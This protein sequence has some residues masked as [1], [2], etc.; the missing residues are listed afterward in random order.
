VPLAGVVLPAKRAAPGGAWDCAGVAAR[1]GV[2]VY[3]N[4]QG[5]PVREARPRS[6]VMRPESLATLRACV[7]TLQHPGDGQDDDA[8]VGEVTAENARALWHGHV[9]EALADTP[10]PGLVM[11]WQRLA[12]AEVH[13]A[14]AAGTV[15]LSCGYEA[16]LRDPRDPE[17]AHLVAELGPEPF[18]THGGERYDLLQTQIRYNHLAVVD[19][20]RAGHIARL[21]L[22]GR[23]AMKITING[24]QHPIQPFVAKAIKA[25]ALDTAAQA[26]AKTDALEVGEITIE[27]QALVLPKA[28]IDQILAMLGGNAGPSVPEPMPT[29]AAPPGAVPPP[30]DPMLMGDAEDEPKKDEK[31]PKAKADAGDIAAQVQRLVRAEMAKLQPGATKAI[32]DSVLATSRE[33]ASLERDASLV[34]GVRH[35][36]AGQDDHAVAVSVLKADGS[37]RVAR[38]EQLETLARKGDAMAAGRLRQ[39]MDDVLDRRRDDQDSSAEMAGWMFDTAASQARVDGKPGDDET[40]ERDRVRAAKRDARENPRGAA[41]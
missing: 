20:A 25:D 23:A 8:G 29:D 10:T 9:I 5:Q 4:E 32:A 33:R 14:T 41:A 11:T 27:G 38:A 19:L 17:V 26:K 16:V 35:D 31:D 1:D 36:Y 28:T 21:R 18:V 40:P 24:K 13:A 15:E 37:P 3:D 22:D 2:Q 39:M 7:L 34:L 12:T 30:K 6:E